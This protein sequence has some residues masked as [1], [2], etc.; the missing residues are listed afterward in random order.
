LFKTENDDFV[1][2]KFTDKGLEVTTE[3]GDVK[4]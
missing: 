1:V 2:V 4:F 3:D